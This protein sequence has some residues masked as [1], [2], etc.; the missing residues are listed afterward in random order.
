MA[1][2][3]T[4]RPLSPETEGTDGAAPAGFATSADATP[5]PAPARNALNP[6][7]VWIVR[8]LARQAARDEWRHERGFTTLEFA[9]IFFAIALLLMALLVLVRHV[10]GH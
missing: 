1:H 9:P 2:T 5:K 3:L 4:M 10:A 7:L 8:L 6:A